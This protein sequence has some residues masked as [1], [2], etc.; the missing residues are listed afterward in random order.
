MRIVITGGTGFLGRS[1]ASALAGRGDQV[2]ILSRSGPP[3]PSADR[4]W[5]ASG[6]QTWRWSASPAL[7]GWRQVVDGADAVVNLAGESI[8]SGRWSAERKARIESS[9][10]EA[11]AAVVAAVATSPSPPSRI[12]SGSAVG[13]YGSDRGDAPQTEASPPDDSFLG[14]LARRWEEVA[15]EARSRGATVALVRTGIVLDPREGVLAS[16]S[17]VFKLFAGGPAGSGAQYMSW[18]HRDDWVA[19]VT[20]LLDGRGDGPYNATA[21]NPVTNAEFSRAL[22][23]VLDRPSWFPT[24]GFVLRTVLGEMADALVLG[25]QRVLPSRALAEGFTFRFGDVAAALEDLY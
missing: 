17:P 20:W 21:P 1:L 8:A 9:R 14:S 3:A 6:I 25:G 18:I 24:P 5:E 13:Y 22:G 12:V 10:L 23:R 4:V 15:G 19:L 11:T 7:E 2:A 16:L